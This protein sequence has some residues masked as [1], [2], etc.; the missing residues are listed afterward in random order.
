[1][2]VRVEHT[3][4]VFVELD[5]D[6]GEI[7]QVVVDDEHL[8]LRHDSLSSDHASITDNDGGEVSDGAIREGSLALLAAEPGPEWPAWRFG[9]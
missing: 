7:L 3:A 6:S 2:R 8:E 5:T 4:P 9:W 1:M